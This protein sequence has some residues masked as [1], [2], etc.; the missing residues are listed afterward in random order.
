MRSKLLD[1]TAGVGSCN[2]RT[3]SSVSL[4]LRHWGRRAQGVY[5]TLTPRGFA[6]PVGS[7]LH[8]VGGGEE[9]AAQI[10]FIITRAAREIRGDGHVLDV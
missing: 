6:R 10:K 3:A 7:R 9:D 4:G 1:W 5:S 8:R 2:P